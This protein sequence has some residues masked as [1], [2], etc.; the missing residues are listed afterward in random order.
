MLVSWIMKHLQ[1]SN[2]AQRAPRGGSLSLP[3]SP[4]LSLSLPPSSDS[5]RNLNIT[6]STRDMEVKTRN[7]LLVKKIKN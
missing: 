5:T 6:I 4:S 1:A 2:Q 7:V 3:P